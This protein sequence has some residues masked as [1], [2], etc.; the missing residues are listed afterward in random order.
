MNWV[1]GI[2]LMVGIANLQ[3]RI[4]DGKIAKREWERIPQ[5]GKEDCGPGIQGSVVPGG[6]SLWRRR[7]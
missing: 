2:W 3:F 4:Q 5:T 1:I 7:Q 6:R